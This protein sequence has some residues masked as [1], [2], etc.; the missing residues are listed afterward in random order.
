[1][2]RSTLLSVAGLVMLVLVGVGLLLLVPRKGRA[3]E[4]PRPTASRTAVPAQPEVPPHPEAESTLRQYYQEIDMAW[5]DMDMSLFDHIADDFTVDDASGTKTRDQIVADFRQ[6][7]AQFAQVD[8]VIV[9]SQVTIESIDVRG[10]TAEVRARAVLT[11]D[12]PGYH[13][14]QT[15]ESIDTWAYR[16]GDWWCVHD[17]VL[18]QKME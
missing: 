13:V 2:N 9:N 3:P 14:V 4:P 10:D 17:K 8:D 15:T 6:I 5:A 12:R 16:N 18:S 1:M 11:F 7:Q